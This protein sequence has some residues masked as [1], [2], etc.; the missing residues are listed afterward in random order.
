DRTHQRHG[1]RDAGNSLQPFDDILAEI[2]PSGGGND[3][4]GSACHAVDRVDEPLEDSLVHHEHR[5][6]DAYAHGNR[7]Y[8]QDGPSEAGADVPVRHSNNED[9]IHDSH[10]SGAAAAIDRPVGGLRT[11]LTTLPSRSSNVRSP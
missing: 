9:E 1:E 10:L 7:G 8:A 5:R 6:D 11:S 4:S 3:E 2:R